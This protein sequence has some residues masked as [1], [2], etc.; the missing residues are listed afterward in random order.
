V[1]VDRSLRAVLRATDGTD[2]IGVVG[3]AEAL[4]IRE[5][6]F[7]TVVA[8][9]VV[10]LLD[11]PGA[12]LEGVARALR[13]QGRLVLSTPDPALG[14]RGGT[15][16]AV[17]DLVEAAGL[18]IVQDLDGMPWVRSHGPRHHQVYLV[19]VLVAEKPKRRPRG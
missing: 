15:D 11:D 18:S 13:P 4:P 10:D 5:K 3:E 6:G 8:A 14:L 9:N 2:A 1:V 17:R 16:E 7:A 12:F 19:R